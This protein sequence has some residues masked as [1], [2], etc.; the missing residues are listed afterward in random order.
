MNV[1][2][3]QI[4]KPS[5]SLVFFIINIFIK[6]TFIYS[7]CIKKVVVINYLIIFLKIT[8]NRANLLGYYCFIYFVTL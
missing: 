6:F 5:T 1:P 8:E 4:R 2:T 7:F 3:L